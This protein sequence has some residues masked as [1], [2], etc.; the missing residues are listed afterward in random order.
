MKSSEK[1]A[2]IWLRT[3][4]IRDRMIRANAEWSG[5]AQLVGR[6]R[7]VSDAQVCVRQVGATGKGPYL[8]RARS[9]AYTERGAESS[10]P[11]KTVSQRTGGRSVEGLFANPNLAPGIQTKA[12][13]LRKQGQRTDFVW[14][15]TCGASRI[16]G[17]GATALLS[18]PAG[19]CRALS[20]SDG[21][22]RGRLSRA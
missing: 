1:R 13:R 19:A 15:M 14:T 7:L 20:D 10:W 18:R 2:R 11:R 6:L 17:R 4:I 8:R 21:F 12:V 16:R 22:G 9:P 5:L 3:W